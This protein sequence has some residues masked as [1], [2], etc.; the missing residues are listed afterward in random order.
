MFACV[1]FLLFCSRFTYSMSSHTSCSDDPNPF[2]CSLEHVPKPRCVKETPA[3]EKKPLGSLDPLA[4][5]IHNQVFDFL[6]PKERRAYV[7]TNARLYYLAQNENRIS[8]LPLAPNR[9]YDSL[10]NRF[11]LGCMYCYSGM[12]KGL[13]CDG[14]GTPCG[15]DNMGSV[16]WG[17]LLG[18]AGGCSPCALNLLTSLHLPCVVGYSIMGGS[19]VVLGTLGCC[20]GFKASVPVQEGIRKSKQ[21]VQDRLQE[22]DEKFKKHIWFGQTPCLRFPK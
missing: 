1:S 22:R 10:L 8:Y 16:A 13:C 4:N 18:V 14:M 9:K 7:L 3:E 17:G 21:Q 5:D 20:V 11:D 19:A 6:E 15:S 12:Q 2:T